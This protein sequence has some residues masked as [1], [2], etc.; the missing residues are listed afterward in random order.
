MSLSVLFGP[1]Q[2]LLGKFQSERHYTDEK[3]DAALLAINKA[4]SKR[5]ATSKRVKARNAS[6]VIRSTPSRSSGRKPQ[7]MRGMRARS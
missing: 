2:D 3:L 4:S 6:T 7:R 5:S 1:L